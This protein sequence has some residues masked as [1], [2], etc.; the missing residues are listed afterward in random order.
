[1]MNLL[2]SGDDAVLTLEWANLIQ[3]SEGNNFILNL[4]CTKL[5]MQYPRQPT[6]IKGYLDI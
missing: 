4:A 5:E 1:M 6:I 3:A 2:V